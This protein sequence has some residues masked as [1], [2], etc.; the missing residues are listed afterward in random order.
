MVKGS[1]LFYNKYPIQSWLYPEL[2]VSILLS[3]YSKPS[4]L[5]SLI[6]LQQKLVVCNLSVFTQSLLF[7]RL[8]MVTCRASTII[9]LRP[10]PVV[11]KNYLYS[12]SQLFLHNYVFSK[13]SS[14][15]TII[16]LLHELVVSTHLYVSNKG[17]LFLHNYLSTAKVSC[18]YTI[19]C[20]Q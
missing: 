9:C 18:F 13:D 3:A 6:C 2:V 11:S 16:F 15:Y 12:K 17:L 19:I 5:C 10:E 8:C 7:L 20:Y 4:C 1:S 14:F